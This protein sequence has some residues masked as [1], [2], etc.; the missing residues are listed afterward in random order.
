MATFVEGGNALFDGL[1]YRPPDP[2]SVAFVQAQFQNPTHNLTAAGQQ[3]FQSVQAIHERL[4]GSH[5]M[6][7][8]RAATRKVASLWQGDEV[9]LLSSI[10]ELQHASLPMQRWVMAEPTVRKWFYQQR[11]EGYE[12]TYVDNAPGDIGV[13]HHDYR[14]VMSG[15]IVDTETGWQATTWFDEP[16]EGDAPLL[17]EEQIDIIDTWSWAKYYLKQG[18]EDPTSVWNADL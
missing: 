10:G 12:G 1:A 2:N 15:V 18:K 11:L 16:L 17:F 4:M 7:V 5:A 3:F 14:R 6:R 8:A 9:R 13:D